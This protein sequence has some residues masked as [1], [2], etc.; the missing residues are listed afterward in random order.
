MDSWTL[1]FYKE[2]VIWKEKQNDQE[3][4]RLT[5]DGMMIPFYRV[6]K[7]VRIIKSSKGINIIAK[8]RW[9]RFVIEMR[10]KVQKEEWKKLK[11]LIKKARFWTLKT[12]IDR[13]GHDGWYI[14]IEGVKKG[15]YHVISRWVP[16]GPVGDLYDYM[17]GL[18]NFPGLR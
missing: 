14:R 16:E 17:T 13:Y 10:R 7:V 12:Y 2:P 6:P 3:I 5:D 1:Y 15:K 9:K 8:I 4:Y 18:A 11:R